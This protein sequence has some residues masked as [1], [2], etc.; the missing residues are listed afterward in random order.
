MKY[1]Y[2]VGYGSDEDSD[3]AELISDEC[4]TK[5]QLRYLVHQA[6]I[7]VLE[8]IK[9]GKDDGIFLTDLGPNYATLHRHVIQK[10]VANHNFELLKYNSEWSCFGWPSV[11][12]TRDWG[13]QRDEDLNKLTAAIPDD[14]KDEINKIA[15]L[16]RLERKA[17]LRKYDDSDP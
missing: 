2:K 7:E 15:E 5:G 17:I 12:D 11:T 6:V 13:T 8:D 3:Y 9:A 16:K 1:A 10:L 14:L 4:F